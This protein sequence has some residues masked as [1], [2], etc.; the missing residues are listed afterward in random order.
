MAG[1]ANSG[2]KGWWETGKAPVFDE[3][4]KKRY[5]PLTMERIEHDLERLGLIHASFREIAVELA[6]EYMLDIN[7][8]ADDIKYFFKRHERAQAAYERGKGRGKLMLRRKQVQVAMDKEVPTMLIWLGK[9]W[10]DQKEKGQH[11]H[12]GKDGGP[13]KVSTDEAIRKFESLVAEAETQTEGN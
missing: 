4:G 3:T 13:I 8:T 11:E 9:Q 1:N 12:T 2:R 7:L 6:H 10:L 5:V